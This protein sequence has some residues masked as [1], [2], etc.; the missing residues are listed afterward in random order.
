MRL[1]YP[2][3]A[4][5][6]LVSCLLLTGRGMA[7]PV[8]DGSVLLT[9]S[10]LKAWGVITSELV[11]GGV[12]D[13]GSMALASHKETNPVEIAKGRNNWLHIFQIDWKSGKATHSSV[14][15]PMPTVQ[16][17]AFHPDGK[18]I[19]CVGQQGTWIMAV[20]IATK[21]ARTIFK[22]ELGK[23]GFRITPPVM[24]LEKG[25]LCTEGYF[26]DE[27]QTAMGDC[28]VSLNPSQ[29]GLAVFDKIVDITAF[30]ER[31]KMH[32]GRNRHSSSLVFFG[33]KE[34]SQQIY[35]YA[36]INNDDKKL[37][38]LDQGKSIDNLATGRDR[39]L[40]A[41]RQSD[42]SSRVRIRDVGSGKTW[43]IG[44]GKSNYTYLY[45][46]RDASQILVSLLDLRHRSMTV[47]Y[48]NE[49][50]NYRLHP[51]AGMTDVLPG[52]I[53]MSHAGGTLSF[54]SEKGL[55]FRRIPTK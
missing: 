15:L 11:L 46:T 17:Y 41:L 1:R 33:L 24:W 18:T 51:M 54:F 10:Q 22:N 34:P 45:M 21:T 27:T 2:F 44:D 8:T 23:K 38:F 40:Y 3:L 13:D 19:V 20:D 35:L 6:A 26:Y 42:G 50:E 55:V 5:A 25:K 52:T 31:S 36:S 12:S 49:D 30:N 14:P 28:V 29:K 7:A 39:C 9:P 43:T 37:M 32:T 53:R 48:G 4:V 47:W 16:N